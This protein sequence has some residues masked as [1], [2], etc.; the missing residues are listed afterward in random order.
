MIILKHL[1]VERF[2]LLREVNFHFPQRGCILIQGPNEAG[3]SAL[4]ESLYFALYGEALSS[5]RGMRSLD[6]LVFYGATNASVT[7]TF[8]V[9][10][11]EL[12]IS[13]VIE[14][15]NGQQA[16][17]QIR[18]LGVNGEE[19]LTGLGSINE[20]IISEM[21]RVD[22]DSL[23]NSYLIEQ[24]GL[25]R[26]ETL[27]GPIR[28][29]TARKLLGL[30]RLIRLSEQFKVGP[31][32]E[33]LLQ[34]WREKLHLAEVQARIPALGAQ[35]EK[36]ELALDAVA[37]CEDLNE[38]ALQ[39]ADLEEQERSIEQMKRHRQ[40]LKSQQTRL[41]Q[42]Q[43]AETTL[44]EIIQAYDTIAEARHNVPEL[45]KQIADLERRES[46]E[47]PALEKRVSDLSELRRSFGTLEHMSNDLLTAGD[48]IK[49]LEQELKKQDEAQDDLQ[50]ME[51]Q[52]S[53]ARQRVQ[54]AQQ[55][56]TD[57]EERRRSGRPQ[58]EARLQRIRN[59]SERLK[60]LKTAED[61]YARAMMN[62]G[63][64]EE[65]EA[66]LRKVQ[67][68]LHETEQEMRLVEGESR[69]IQRQTEATEKRW[70]DLGVRRHMEEW[71]RLKSLADGL[72]QAEQQVRMAHEQ[73]ARFNQAAEDAQ[74]S[75]RK[76]LLIVV[77][78]A[79]FAIICAILMV[80]EWS[81][82][83]LV[84]TIAGVAALILVGVSW[85]SYM[86]FR[87]ARGEERAVAAQ[88]QDAVNRLGMM[89]AARETAKR[90]GGSEE[91]V[92]QIERE[93]QQLG[94]PLPRSIEDAQNFM[95][96]VPD[97]GESLADLQQQV[98][99]RRDE[100]NASRSQ[101]NVT[102]E[103]VALLRKERSRLEDQRAREQWD[104]V[105]ERIET[106]RANVKRFRQ[107]IAQLASSEGLPLPTMNA[108]LRSGPLFSSA[109]TP[110]PLPVEDGDLSLPDLENLI[111]T[112]L[113]TAERELATLDGRL[114]MA[115]DLAQ[116]VKV[117][118]DALDVL[119]VRQ[120]VIEER[121]ERYKTNNPAQQ[122]ERAREQQLGLRQALRSL[123]D[124]LRQRVKPLG[125]T[126]GQAAINTAE[127]ASRKQLEELQIQ[128]GSKV[129]LQE[130]LE[131]FSAQLQD[132]QEALSEYY[133]QLAKFSNS[134]GS[135]IVPLNPFAEAL[136]SL[137]T[138]CQNEIRE[139][140]EEEILKELENSLLQQGAATLRIELCR[141]E[142]ESLGESLLARLKQ[143]SRSRPRS[144]TRKDVVSVWPLVGQ[145]TADDRERLEAERI[146]TEQELTNLEQ[147]ELRLSQELH[148][149]T[150]PLDLE[151]TRSRLEQQEHVYETHK[152]GGLL[153]KAV[154]DR[155]MHKL[156]PR[157]EYYM[158]QLLPLL[159]SHRYHDVHLTTEPEEGTAS[160]GAFRLRVWEAAAGEYVSKDA[161]STGAA[162]QLSLALRLAF[163][164][165]TL[166]RE[167]NAVP[168]FLFL[169]EPLSSFDQSRTQALVDVMTGDILGQ[170]FEQILL[171]SHSNAFNPTMF[172]Y[173]VYM[174][175]GLVV[176][177]NLPV[178]PTLP[179]SEPGILTGFDEEDSFDEDED[180]KMNTQARMPVVRAATYNQ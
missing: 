144:F 4:L 148:T 59:L 116:Q 93:I 7:L 83:L 176:E 44:D 106:E 45:E 40:E 90:M 55:S 158:Q 32:D 129:V 164:I 73:K 150:I 156:V 161:L 92:G 143:R 133:K 145:F 30:E 99:E 18:R 139:A 178:V 154:I 82:S 123:Q 33:R 153:I 61:E 177:S 173:H 23:R 151:Q 159:T 28:E 25:D 27:S 146:S 6:D 180:D 149:G 77:I 84:T 47:L 50:N 124:S 122:I 131:H 2:R 10:A 66:R 103:A 52:I 155:L 29:L 125:V 21:G 5:G 136:L 137:R 96:R 107:E 51:E 68:D 41:H 165:A 118:Q 75:S 110:L 112:T 20:R 147:Q 95:Q 160:S 76:Y 34:E 121:N 48:T 17:L 109:L 97:D 43:M 115:R 60:T 114:D 46:E 62:Q 54:Q 168:G 65:N 69:Q 102:M 49:E 85:I 98:K 157:T 31:E 175:N 8:S 171:I 42:L 22:G 70:R 141:Q 130:K 56:L 119:L 37:A 128:L 53:H 100:L 9:G 72:L 167:L 12:T 81:S 172:P 166:P 14:R 39:E 74:S 16:T 57:L 26:L 64:A 101:V 120:S 108:R 79:V 89:V 126:F 1:T 78:C 174:D 67:R 111:N 24:K 13:R 19:T 117:H 163:A 162:D 15:G 105:K 71:I 63:L 140:N 94:G 132:R 58:L 134:L 170:H 135:W 88:I 169:D 11:T 91:A 86:S 36:S 152:R 179:V 35:L 87:K 113:K 142:I 138:R 80:A 38:I 127:I 3:K 104:T